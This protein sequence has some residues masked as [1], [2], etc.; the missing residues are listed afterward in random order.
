MTRW[1][2]R[3]HDE[4]MAVGRCKVVEVAPEARCRQ[5]GDSRSDVQ[6]PS[7]DPWPNVRRDHTVRQVSTQRPQA[8]RPG[9]PIRPIGAVAPCPQ[10]LAAI[11]HGVNCETGHKLPHRPVA[12]NTWVGRRQHPHCC[13]RQHGHPQS[14]L[15]LRADIM[16]HWAI[17][18]G[19]QARG[20][21]MHPVQITRAPPQT[22]V[23]ARY[24]IQGQAPQGHLMVASARMFV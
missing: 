13:P 22:H 1:D 5:V 12:M 9:I 10:E 14:T 4:L 21:V 6:P 8:G 16:R 3:V 20:V 23:G 15:E 19:L 24:G 18:E 7:E 11:L 2:W 17:P